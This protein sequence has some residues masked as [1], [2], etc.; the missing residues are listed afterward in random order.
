MS[1]EISDFAYWA[2]FTGDEFGKVGNTRFQ[3]KRA[4]GEMIS[5]IERVVNLMCGKY[6]HVQSSLGVDIAERMLQA[7]REIDSYIVWDVNDTTKS[8][9]IGESTFDVAVMISGIAYLR[10]PEHTFSETCRILK[11]SG[12]FILGYDH[13][14]TDRGT[15]EW[16]KM[17]PNERLHKLQEFYSQN[18]F[19]DQEVLEIPIDLGFREFGVGPKVFFL[20][21]AG[22]V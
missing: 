20:V 15:E 10:H 9:P 4:L 11:R 13:N 8:Y 19:G 12:R 2:G 17:S 1:D 16:G 5:P 7:N 18:G 3:L 6:A 22:K 14:Q 21:S